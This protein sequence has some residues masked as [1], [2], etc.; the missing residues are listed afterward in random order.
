MDREHRPA[1]PPP[2]Y[3]AAAFA[4]GAGLLDRAL[5]RR[6]RPG[7]V[8]RTVGSTL[9]ALGATAIT[10][11][12]REMHRYHTTPLP[13]RE[14]SALVRTGPFAYTR[15]PIYV[16]MAAVYAG[17]AALRGSYGPWLT[18]PLALGL[19]DRTVVQ[20][21]EDVLDARFG[22]TFTAYRWRT[23]RWVGLPH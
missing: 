23:P 7:P 10:G 4:V 14:P 9:I 12:L 8:G 22:G 3:F 13:F 11:S 16:G 1:P 18:L 2:A 6:P 17:A 5:P 15:H 21:E 19:L 20:R